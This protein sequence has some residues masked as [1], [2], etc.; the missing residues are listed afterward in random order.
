MPSGR[1]QY[2]AC[3]NDSVAM[4]YHVINPYIKNT[5]ILLCPS[6]TSTGNPQCA[7][8][9]PWAR[10]QNVYSHYAINCTFGT[11]GGVKMAAVRQPASVLYLCEANNTGAGWWRGFLGAQGACIQGSY[12]RET[13]NGGNNF[14][15]ADGHVKWLQGPRAF[16]PTKAQF[17]AN[18]PWAPT[19]DTLL[20]GY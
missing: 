18:L 9:F 17:D 14:A 8:F 13:H 4:W 5:Q 15:Y 16:A 7:K 1:P 19:S 12:Y 20:A 11:S 6:Q 10:A 3:A 2:L